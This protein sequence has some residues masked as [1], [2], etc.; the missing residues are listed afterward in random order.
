MAIATFDRYTF[1]AELKDY[2]EIVAHG[3]FLKLFG[4]SLKQNRRRADLS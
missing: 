2:F 1:L 4:E 3:T